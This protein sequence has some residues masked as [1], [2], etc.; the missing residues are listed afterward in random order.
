MDLTTTAII[1]LFLVVGISFLIR[2]NA[3]PKFIRRG[4]API[5]LGLVVLIGLVP[6]GTL[7][8]VVPEWVAHEKF[9]FIAIYVTIVGGI[10]GPSCLMWYKAKGVL[11]TIGY[12]G[13][14]ICINIIAINLLLRFGF[15]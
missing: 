9:R 8:L 2:R 3:D 7:R 6:D 10:M 11:S 1:V 12:V 15:N 4:V 14:A 5:I 13:A